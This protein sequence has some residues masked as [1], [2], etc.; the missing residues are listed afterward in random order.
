M[1]PLICYMTPQFL[2]TGASLKKHLPSDLPLPG[3]FEPGMLQSISSDFC[4]WLSYSSGLGCKNAVSPNSTKKFPWS[5]GLMSIAILVYTLL[6]ENGEQNAYLAKVVLSN[7]ML[8]TDLEGGFFRQCRTVSP[9]GETVE[10]YLDRARIVCKKA[11]KK[12][13]SP[14]CI[15]S[16][17]LL[18]AK[19]MNK[20]CQSFTDLMGI[21][22]HYMPS[23][24][25]MIARDSTLLHWLVDI[26]KPKHI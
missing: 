8:Y 7:F 24:I 19:R 12:H 18:I 5:A 13:P 16:S 26:D 22:V 11:R 14:A 25:P 1:M 21:N 6:D 2:T 3:N 15:I 4:W 20:F 9:L 10:H 17:H 23:Y